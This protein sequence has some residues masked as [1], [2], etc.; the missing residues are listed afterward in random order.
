M[1]TMTM[2]IFR[3]HSGGAGEWNERRWAMQKT[4]RVASAMKGAGLVMGLCLLGAAT[5]ARALTLP[6]PTS[7]RAAA[8]LM[9]PKIVVDSSGAFGNPTDTLIQLS[10]TVPL[11]SASSNRNHVKQAHCFYIN[12]TGHCSNS[13]STG[14]LNAGQCD[15]GGTFG[16]CIPGWSEIDFDVRVTP[17]QPLAWLASAGLVTCSSADSCTP[18]STFPISSP[19]TCSN[20][21]ITCTSINDPIC[22]GGTCN[23][24]AS[25][26][27]SGVPP[28]P[29]DPFVGSLTCIQFD[30]SANPAAPDVSTRAN[31]L[32][33]N[34]T[35]EDIVN[36]GG[37]TDPQKYNAVGIRKI[38]NGACSS[39]GS[40]CS[41]D[42][43]CSTGP[44]GYCDF[45]Q[46][47]DCTIGGPVTDVLQLGGASGAQ[48]QGCPGKLILNHVFDGACDPL[49]GLCDGDSDDPTVS[50]D[51]TLI[52]CGNDFLRQTPG[53][54]TAQ[55]L[56]FNEFEQRFSTSRTVDC[57]FESAISNI[58]TPNNS[59]SIFSFNVAGTLV[60]QTL[61]R[62]V[63]SAS[64]G[65]GLLG[66][67]RVF[68]TPGASSAT[69]R[70]PSGAAYNL[71]ESGTLSD[72][73]VITIP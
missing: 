35:I 1:E 30:P 2:N 9:W 29:E 59:H 19:G 26:A 15:I 50:T 51:L 28:A 36:V 56:V 54:V 32:I 62:G 64:T 45:E 65:N 22:G 40:S 12:A 69:T 46:A 37:E 24:Q 11:G 48:Y 5:T 55:F 4:K 13:P 23:L 10:S 53:R 8:I 6:I 18:T 31:A 38:C 70:E 20:A 57:F 42:T 67:A 49:S 68:T 27:G 16:A 72:P 52:P 34:A 73:D 39:D 43:D 47:T 25:N 44:G 17:E 63:G 14:C 33:G 71:H 21:P 66:V 61:I 7:D 3:V 41:S 60:G 58:D